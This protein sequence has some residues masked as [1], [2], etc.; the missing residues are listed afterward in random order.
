[1]E[2]IEKIRRTPSI[3]SFRF[4]SKERIN[5]QPGQFLKVILEETGDEVT[6]FRFTVTAEGDVIN[7]ND[8]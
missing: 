2:L 6:V 1:M 3:E 5:F 8:L 4:K 7:I